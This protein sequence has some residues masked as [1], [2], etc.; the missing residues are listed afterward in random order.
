MILRSIDPNEPS[1]ARHSARRFRDAA[2]DSLGIAALRQHV[3]GVL[4]V[5]AGAGRVRLVVQR[6]SL[7]RGARGR[8]HPAA[9]AES[10]GQAAAAGHHRGAVQ[11]VDQHA[12][13]QLQR[14]HQQVERNA[15]DQPDERRD[16]QRFLGALQHDAASDRMPPT[17]VSNA[18][19]YDAERVEDPAAH[20]PSERRPL[21]EP[22]FPPENAASRA[23]RRVTVRHPRAR[24]R[25]SHVFQAPPGPAHVQQHSRR[26]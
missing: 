10:D 18:R 23:E 24:R 22:T 6:R 4:H 20:N 16:P 15:P 12:D 9:A 1:A 19:I 17:T 14:R 3:D 8:H 21:R 26:S 5:A 13:V 25:A 11:P 2:R 7:Q